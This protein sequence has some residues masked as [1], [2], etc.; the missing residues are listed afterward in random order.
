[1]P[2]PE[3]SIDMTTLNDSLIRLG[4]MNEAMLKALEKI[5]KQGKTKGIGKLMRSLG[6]TFKTSFRESFEIQKRGLARGVQLTG[7]NKEMDPTVEGLSHLTDKLT[8]SQFVMARFEA[9]MRGS[10]SS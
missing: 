7:M 6:G 8:A 2:P 10:N 5:E 4:D 3:G 1:M 9:G